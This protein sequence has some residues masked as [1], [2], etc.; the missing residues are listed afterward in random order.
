MLETAKNDSVGGVYITK[1]KT[2]SSVTTNGRQR[3]ENSV[4]QVD[5]STFPCLHGWLLIAA[6]SPPHSLVSWL[7]CAP[8]DGHSKQTLFKEAGAGPVSAAY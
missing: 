4:L 2:A 6:Q 7:A 5:T 8:W 1:S 3:E